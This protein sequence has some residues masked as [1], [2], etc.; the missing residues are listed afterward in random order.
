MLKLNVSLY[1]Y[2]DPDEFNQISGCTIAKQIWDTFLN[3]LDVT[4]QVRNLE[5][6]D[7]SMS[8]KPSMKNG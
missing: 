5:L 7:S 2:S 3:E 6:V 8:T 1:V 4:T